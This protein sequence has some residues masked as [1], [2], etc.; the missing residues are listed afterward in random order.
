[1]SRKSQSD[2][3]T[4]PVTTAMHFGTHTPLASNVNTHNRSQQTNPGKHNRHS[5]P[6]RSTAVP[7]IVPHNE[8]VAAPDTGDYRINGRNRKPDQAA[9]Q[10]ALTMACT[11]CPAHTHTKA[12]DLSVVTASLQTAIGFRKPVTST[13]TFPPITVPQLTQNDRVRAECTAPPAAA[14]V[15]QP[16]NLLS[17]RPARTNSTP[18]PS[19]TSLTCKHTQTT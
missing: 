14:A 13:E 18:P 17:Q 1:M 10:D 19:R 6:D 11:K 9:Q 7:H 5:D 16:P 12:S 8:A 4:Q 2:R 3:H 15:S